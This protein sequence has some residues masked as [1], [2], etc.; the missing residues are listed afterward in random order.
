MELDQEPLW[1]GECVSAKQLAE[2]DATGDG[3]ECRRGD[4]AGASDGLFSLARDRS[5]VN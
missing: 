3:V 1:R 2:G 5:S 4:G